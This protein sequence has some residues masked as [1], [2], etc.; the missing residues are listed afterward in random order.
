LENNKYIKGLL[1]H[2]PKILNAIYSDFSGKI[3]Y[4]IQQKGG[5]KNDA[6]DI[7]HDALMVIYQKAQSPDFKLTSQ[8]Y[9]YLYSICHFMWDRKSKK[10]ANNTVTI[11]DDNRLIL[12]GDIIADIEKRE[13]QNVFRDNVAKLGETC[14]KVLR[15][16]F[17]KKSMTEIAAA[18][19]FKNEHI[20]R[21]RK[22]RCGKELEKL[23]RNDQR[24]AELASKRP[25]KS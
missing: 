5:T 25:H 4:H 24:Y 2:D 23:I 16:F 8:F 15:L 12:E 11:P 21:T 18:L 19:E 3:Q 1:T 10:K 20:A 17:E 7:F 6:K 9:T 13:K 14:R 22:Y